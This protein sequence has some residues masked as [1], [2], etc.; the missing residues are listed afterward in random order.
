[1]E[2]STS[3]APARNRVRA[4]QQGVRSA[5]QQRGLRE[6]GSADTLVNAVFVAARPDDVDALAALPGVRYVREMRPIRMNMVKANEVIRAVAAATLA[7]PSFHKGNGT[8]TPRVTRRSR[9]L[10]SSLV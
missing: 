1:M 5:L 6:L 10:P 3:F 4:S 8:C 9:L 2:G 7:E